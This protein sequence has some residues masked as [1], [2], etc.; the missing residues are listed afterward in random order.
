MQYLWNLAIL[1]FSKVMDCISWGAYE[2][3]YSV[4]VCVCVCV[5]V[6]GGLAQL[7][8]KAHRWWWGLKRVDSMMSLEMSG[9]WVPGTI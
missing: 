3:S 4:C 6:C 2:L 9:H 1:T 8:G 7:G 5:Y